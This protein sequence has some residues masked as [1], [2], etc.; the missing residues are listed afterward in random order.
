LPG[1]ALILVEN[2]LVPSEPRLSQEA[3]TLRRS[4]ELQRGFLGRLSHELRTPLTAIRGW[5]DA[6]RGSGETAIEGRRSGA[7]A[8]AVFGAQFLSDAVRS[9]ASTVP[10]HSTGTVLA[11][12]LNPDPHRRAFGRTS[13]D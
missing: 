5:G 7:E 13:L 8:M 9:F 3:I 10:E 6:W 4:Q 1:R 12:R 11:L 2:P